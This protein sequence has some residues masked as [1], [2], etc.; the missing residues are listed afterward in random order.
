MVNYVGTESVTDPGM[1]FFYKA[2]A[3]I[4]PE[5]AQS[6]FSVEVLINKRESLNFSFHPVCIG[7]EREMLFLT[8]RNYQDETTQ[9]TFVQYF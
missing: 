7:R 1:A 5:D 3:A 9:R 8:T 2:M 6:I 4:F